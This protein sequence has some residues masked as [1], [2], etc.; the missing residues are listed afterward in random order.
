MEIRKAKETDIVRI[1]Q[2]Y[3]IARD[4]MKR[5]GNPSQWGDSYPP[6]ETVRDDIGKGVCR[7]ISDQN[8]IHG[9]FAAIEGDDP[10]Y[11]YIEGAWLN[12]E[13]YVT[14]H[15]IASD[16]TSHGIFRIAAE[17]CKTLC[18]N[19]RIDTHKD[20]LT[21]QHLLDKNG[22][23]KCGVIYLLNGSPR[24]AYQLNGGL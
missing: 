11:G 9:V 2:I 7:V 19:V 14:I 18:N 5:S 10:T 4:Y 23:V 15:R 24:I 8:G 13:P 16:G 20:N 1:M 3:A 21:M 17:Y 12:E 6:E 22:F